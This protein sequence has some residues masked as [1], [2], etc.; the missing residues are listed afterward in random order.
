[1]PLFDLQ[2]PR[3]G[4]SPALANADAA[5]A[6]LATQSQ[7]VPLR[8][9]QALG[10]QLDALL[11]APHDGM[12]RATIVEVLRNA[13]LTAH[14]AAR[15][16]FAYQPRPLTGEAGTLFIAGR[17]VAL[18]IAANY[19]RCVEEFAAQT[20]ADP[21]KLATAAHRAMLTL[22]LLCEDFFLAGQEVPFGIWSNLQR[23]LAL[24]RTQRVEGLDIVD[25]EVRDPSTTTIAAQHAVLLLTALCDP[26]RLNAAQF[27]VLQRALFRWR[28][29]PRMGDEPDGSAK[30]RW[31]S[32]AAICGEA[33]DAP[34]WIEI[35]AVRAKLKGRIK[36]LDEG[37]SP[38]S[39][40][41]GRD[42]SARA[43]RD[44][45][46]SVLEALRSRR[47]DA[48]EARGAGTLRVAAGFDESFVLLG[49]KSANGGGAPKSVA[50]S[51]VANERMAIFGDPSAAV[52]KEDEP[53]AGE[54]W[55]LV[56]ESMDAETLYRPA[57]A[58]GNA[59]V[60]T[61]QLIAVGG[62]SGHSATLGVITRAVVDT[63]GGLEIGV[64][65]FPGQPV[66][67]SATSASN[68]APMTFPLML[69]PEV[70]ALQ[71]APSV[72]LPSGTAIRLRQAIRANGYPSPIQLG[73][74][75]ERGNDF[76][77]YA[78]S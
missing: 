22:R 23:L 55:Q 39:L 57:Q 30:S 66:A 50:A 69:L 8:I 49:G 58:P 68:A 59:R 42:L 10:E 67:L 64:R 37:E 35:S 34:Q 60:L 46:D 73:N 25:P 53:A 2:A 51:R 15:R 52:S 76:E 38:E 77:R 17:R 14:G 6:W 13:A 63:D 3:E 56:K 16:K 4:N 65:R 41:L 47:A 21:V 36:A 26:Y 24:A 20:P 70:A 18:L 62:T 75:L 48:S 33:L 1:M 78:L 72:I 12:M 40:Q 11:A 54:A 45:L 44:F 32:L 43:C 5:R 29:L 61:G 27:A 74:L 19:L 7:A 9:M 71:V 31:L 28:D